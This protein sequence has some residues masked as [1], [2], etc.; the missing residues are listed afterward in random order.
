LVG[1]WRKE[2]HGDDSKLLSLSGGA[3]Q[4]VVDP[5]AYIAAAVTKGNAPARPRLAN[6]QP[7]RSGAT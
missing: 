1:K 6:Y 7:L 4:S 3:S 5:A 2:L